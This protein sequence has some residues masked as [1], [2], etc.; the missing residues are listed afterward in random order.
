VPLHGA[1]GE[2]AEGR[3]AVILILTESVDEHADDVAAKLQERGRKHVRFDPGLLPA[4]AQ[5]SVACDARGS[6][7]RT[8]RFGGGNVDLDDVRVVWYRR[9]RPPVAHAELRDPSVR[10]FVAEECQE[11]ASDLFHGIQAPWLPGPPHIVRRAEHKILQLQLASRLG[12]ELPPTLVTNR[13]EDFLEFRRDHSGVVSKLM[14][15]AFFRAFGEDYAR[16]TEPVVRRDLGYARSVRF[17]PVLFQAAIPKK[18]ELRITVVGRQVFAAAIHSQE[19]NHTRHDWRR[20]DKNETIY[21]P[22][23]L[24]RA[25]EAQCVALVEQLGLLFGAIDMIVTP[26]GRHVFLE[27]NPNGQYL[28]I[29]HATGLPIGDAICDLLASRSEAADQGEKP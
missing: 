16:Y 5:I 14:G 20:Y 10:R 12:F 21:T 8:L 1:P 15:A 11:V 13:P 7:T 22:Y 27:I 28:W 26:D 18:V 25:L 2:T 23:D 6:F 24:P 19:S 9:P 17:C 29:E 4:E 3:R